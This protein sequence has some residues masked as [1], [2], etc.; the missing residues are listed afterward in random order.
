[1]R[2]CPLGNI[3]SISVLCVCEVLN[4][5]C[6]T[7]AGY[8]REILSFIT[9]FCC[10]SSCSS[11]MGNGEAVPVPSNRRRGPSETGAARWLTPLSDL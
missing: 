1:M 7:P 4:L 9:V 5:M 11:S 8:S 6:D 10:S 2:I 3:V